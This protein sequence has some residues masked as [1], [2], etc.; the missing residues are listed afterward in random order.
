M[1]LIL[2]GPPGAG[3]GTQAKFLIE[4]YG[5]VQLSTGDIL[6]KAIADETA[7]G[8]QAKEI[9]ARGDLVSDDVVNAII[10]ERLDSEDC[11]K[12]FILDGFPRTLK[13]AD[14]LSAMLL[15]KNMK[16]DAVIEL[17]VD[18][19]ALVARILMRAKEAG[20]SRADDNE[21]VVRNRLDVYRELTEPLVA[22][23]EAK[24][25]LRTV[26]GMSDMQSVKEAIRKA[27]QN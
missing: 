9:M 22:Y 23:Y 25:L 2:L 18:E 15:E 19:E 7:L 16:L 11:Q 13:Q 24:G 8:L 4:E 26:N 12:G 14:S 21:T 6:R 5:I 20:E 1:K 10:S 3:K 17:K 27:L